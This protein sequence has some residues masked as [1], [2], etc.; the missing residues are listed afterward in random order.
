M[1]R[2]RDLLIGITLL[3]IGM[4]GLNSV[5]SASL[6]PLGMMGGMMG[7]RMM[8]RESM[9]SMMKN[10]MGNQ[11]PMG[12]TARDLP[13]A[14]SSGAKLLQHY[15]TQCHDLPGP[16]IHTANEWPAVVG[17]MLDRMRMM[18]KRGMMLMMPDIDMP[19]TTESETLIAYLRQYAQQPI[20]PSQ[21]T[22]LESPA[23]KLFQTTCAQCHALPEPKQHTANEWPDVVKRMTGNMQAMNVPVPDSQTLDGILGYLKKHARQE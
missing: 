3:L 9:K 12:I 13:D 2:N 1:K 20:D 18:S 11:L 5:P 10:M 8:N 6:A 7:G 21:Y 19:S 4:I 17:R 15:C 23:G 22:D 14:E 16:G